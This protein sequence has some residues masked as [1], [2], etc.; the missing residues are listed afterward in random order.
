MTDKDTQPAADQD[1][2]KTETSPTPEPR[3]STSSKAQR[4]AH[5]RKQTGLGGLLGFVRSLFW[6]L[7][8]A[9]LLALAYGGWLLWQQQQSQHNRLQQIEQGLTEQSQDLQR[10][11]QTLSQTRESLTRELERKLEESE[12]DSDQRL[13]QLEQN[14]SG[15]NRRLSRIAGG[16]REDWKL[17]EVEYLLRLANQ[18]LVLENDARNALALAETADRI[19]RQL[20]NPDLIPIRRSLSTDIQA[21]KLTERPDREG[22]YLELLALDQQLPKLRLAQSPGARLAQLESQEPGDSAEV[23]PKEPGLWGS[24]K[25]SFTRLLQ[26]L[27][28]YIR[29]RHHNQP[30]EAL[31]LDARDRLHLDRRLQL[32][33]EQARS[34]LMREQSDIYRASLERAATWLERHYALSPQSLGLAQRL[35]ALAQVEIA[36][37]LPDIDAAL[38]QLSQYLEQRHRLSSE[39]QKAPLEDEEAQP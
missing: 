13:Q 25:G 17:A 28:G 24:I 39:F 5:P 9:L 36:P 19:L 18:R 34:A 23:Q 27:D 14:L 1:P 30:P 11:Q 37:E 10:Q 15:L 7:L 29:V 6:W 31:P 2:A 21:L 3:G 16:E 4:K 33:L 26:R 20:D 35:E 32:Q 22:I 8:L 12:R 38:N